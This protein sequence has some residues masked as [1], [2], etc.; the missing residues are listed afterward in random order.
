MTPG[1]SITHPLGKTDI[2]RGGKPRGLGLYA[3]RAAG[4]ARALLLF[5]CLL[6]LAA[7]GADAEQVRLCTATI[8]A[9][10]EDAERATIVRRERAPDRE[11]AV[12]VRWQMEGESARAVT[13]TFAG[14]AFSPGRLELVELALDGR[15][16]LSESELF[17]LRRWL[18]MPAEFLPVRPSV[19]APLREPLLPLLY[20]L[21]QLINAITLA[22]VYGLLATGYTLVY[23]VVGQI[24]LAFGELTMLAAI[25][26]VVAGALLG[27]A[28]TAAAPLGLLAVLGLA[29]A[30]GMAGAWAS[31]RLVFRNLRGAA[32]HVPLIAAVGLAILLQEA[33]RLLHG[34]GDL[35]L[36]PPSSQRFTVAGGAGFPVVLSLSQLFLLSLTITVYAIVLRL[37]VGTR[38]GLAHR[39]C[40]ADRT[41]A[42]LLGVDVDRTV[43]RS[44]LLGG[45]LAG[46]AGFVIVEYYGVANF[47]MGLMLGFKALAAAIV[48][49]IGSVPGAMLG[50][51]VVAGLEIL[52]SGYFDLAAKDI[53]V[54]V[55]LTLVLVFRPT[56]LLGKSPL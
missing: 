40:A 54:F 53:A 22:C 34:S 37:L 12:T 31:D 20:A 14:G 19:P 39:A 32:P 16:P 5:C 4:R 38:F 27:A 7:C 3:A 33:A 56:G 15:G 51:A 2:A 45:A 50:A 25:V 1:R 41:T 55:L 47:F 28:G 6:G 23:A 13:C 49:G 10:V 11:H 24:N 21:Q 9:F 35:W 8:G 46:L 48:G 17:W 36:Q 30:I 18:A 29:A 26:T 43:A 44:F 42:A 52:W